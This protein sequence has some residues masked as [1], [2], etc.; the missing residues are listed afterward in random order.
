MVLQCF[1]TLLTD[2]MLHFACIFS[3]NVA[4]NAKANKPISQPL[5]SLINHFSDLAA[6]VS[7]INITSLSYGNFPPSRKFFIAMLTLDFLNPIHLR[8]RQSAQLAAFC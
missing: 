2:Y 1:K 3:S 6:T 8:Y 7:K 5:M 4:V